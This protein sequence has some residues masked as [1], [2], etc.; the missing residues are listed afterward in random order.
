MNSKSIAVAAI[1]SSLR[2]K[3]EENNPTIPLWFL[4]YVL[5]PL[6]TFAAISQGLAE[7]HLLLAPFTSFA[8]KLEKYRFATEKG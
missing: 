6:L 8:T 4:R 2:E 7:S 5:C 1:V 3:D